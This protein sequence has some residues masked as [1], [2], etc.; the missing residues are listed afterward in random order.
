MVKHLIDISEKSNLKIKIYKS[1]HGLNSVSDVIEDL[2][3]NTV[4]VVE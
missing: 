3:L 2:L 1:Q 4:V